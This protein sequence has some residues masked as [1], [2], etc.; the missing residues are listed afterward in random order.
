MGFTSYTRRG[1]FEE[2]IITYLTQANMSQALDLEKF[3]NCKSTIASVENLGDA[4]NDKR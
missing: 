1:T 2:G 4:Q 3:P